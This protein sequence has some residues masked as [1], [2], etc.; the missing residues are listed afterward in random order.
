MPGS[1]DSTG[2][3]IPTLSELVAEAQQAIKDGIDQDLDVEEESELGEII[4]AFSGQLAEAYELIQA[5]FNAQSPSSGSGFGLD[6][7]SEVTGSYRSPA[8]KSVKFLDL[9][10]DAGTYPIGTLIVHVTGRPDARFANAS[11]V[12]SPGGV[13][14]AVRMEAEETGP[15]LAYS[16]TLLVIAEAVTGFNS[17]D[18]D[19]DDALLGILEES[20]TALRVKRVQE[21]YRRGS[22]SVNA[23]AAD[24]LTVEGVTFA[25]V[26][27]NDT[28]VTDGNGQPG[29][30]VQA[31]VL[32]GTDQSLRD[33][34]LLSKAAGIQ[35]FGVV[36]GTAVDSAGNS[37][38]IAFTRPTGIPITTDIAYSYLTSV[39]PSAAAANAAVKAALMAES[40]NQAVGMDVVT[41]RYIKAVMNVVGIVDCAPQWSSGGAP[42]PSNY[43]IGPLQLAAL[44]EA[45][46]FPVPTPVGGYP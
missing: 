29:K 43:V 25:T 4:G 14:A 13:V 19:P 10:L 38:T 11:G 12:T 16:N 45:Q 30:S 44:I 20:D 2:L 21:I 42:S 9:N 23:I 3:T 39:F 15:V 28:L 31:V 24:L 27:E 32:G 35:A 33:Q 22:T 41:T 18:D 46:I 36:S 26:L 1:L 7:V 40:A 6:Q 34:L 17:V 8:T 37:H 5:G